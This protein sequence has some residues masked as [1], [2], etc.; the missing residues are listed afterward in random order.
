MELVNAVIENKHKK[1]IITL[2][3]NTYTM[4]NS[5][6]QKD[7]FEEEIKKLFLEMMGSPTS[8]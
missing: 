6:N 7:Y 3:K 5:K 4:I 8:Q 2:I 1:G